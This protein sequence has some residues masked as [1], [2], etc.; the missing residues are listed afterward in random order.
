MTTRFTQGP[1]TRETAMLVASITTRGRRLPA[2][3]KPLQG[4]SGHVNTPLVPSPPSS[5]IT[6]SPEVR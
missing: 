2:L 6:T 5:Q 1:S 4:R 3:G